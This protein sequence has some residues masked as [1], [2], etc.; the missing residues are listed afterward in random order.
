LQ[1]HVVSPEEKCHNSKIQ[2]VSSVWELAAK[3]AKVTLFYGKS[4]AT[5]IDP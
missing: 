5:N 3:T 1:A 4:I 2:F